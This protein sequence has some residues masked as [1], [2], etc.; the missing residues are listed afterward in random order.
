MESIGY[1]GP[2][3]AVLSGPAQ[4][5]F[6]DLAHLPA[7][8]GRDGANAGDGR[9]RFRQ[10]TVS[11]QFQVTEEEWQR[12][13]TERDQFEIGWMLGDGRARRKVRR[14]VT[15]GAEQAC[16][17]LFES[18]GGVCGDCAHELIVAVA[19][20]GVKVD[21]P[22]HTREFTLATASTRFRN[23]GNRLTIKRAVIPVC[24]QTAVM[25]SY[26]PTV[27]LQGARFVYEGHSSI[28]DPQ[29]SNVCG[30]SPMNPRDAPAY[31]RKSYREVRHPKLHQGR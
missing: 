23:G 22:F 16:D 28:G 10:V 25:H 5:G 31:S 21:A 30:L 27:T 2:L 7:L 20:D 8:V 14:F 6:R 11:G 29:A 13:R 24:L 18:F 4:P 15:P 9:Q 17:R 3:V 1:A 12:N 19:R 26:P